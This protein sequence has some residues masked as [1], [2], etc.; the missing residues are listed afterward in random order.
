MCVAAASPPCECCDGTGSNE[1]LQRDELSAA[2][3]A[4]SHSSSTSSHS[5]HV[6][7]NQRCPAELHNHASTKGNLQGP[8]PQ[9]RQRRPTSNVHVLC[10]CPNPKAAELDEELRTPIWRHEEVLK[11]CTTRRCATTTPAAALQWVWLHRWMHAIIHVNQFRVG[12]N[13][14]WRHSHTLSH[15]HTRA[16]A[17]AGSTG[18]RLTKPRGNNGIHHTGQR[19]HWFVCRQPLTGSTD[20]STGQI[21]HTNKPSIYPTA[22]RAPAPGQTP[23]SRARFSAYDESQLARNADEF[24]ALPPQPSPP[25]LLLQARQFAA[26]Q[27]LRCTDEHG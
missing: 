14:R 5:N 22:R 9:N 6:R 17:N 20:T 8:A 7:Q 1:L 23:G 18:W 24:G 3:H 12:G 25:P 15:T 26:S 19:R 27:G 4:S 21:G 13:H 11:G 10:C 16:T 2:E